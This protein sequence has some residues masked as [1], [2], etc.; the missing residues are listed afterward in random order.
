MGDLT[1]AADHLT[2]EEVKAKMKE[3]KDPK[4]LQ[5]WQIIS[6]ALIRPSIRQKK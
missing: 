2:L 3:A 1:R 5:R 4:H 6:T